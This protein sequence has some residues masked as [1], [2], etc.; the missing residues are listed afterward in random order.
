LAGKPPETFQPPETFKT[1]SINGPPPRVGA[2]DT[3]RPKKIIKLKW[4]ANVMIASCYL[5]ANPLKYWPFRGFFNVVLRL[6]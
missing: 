3:P 2:D 4:Q 5:L 1:G 6:L